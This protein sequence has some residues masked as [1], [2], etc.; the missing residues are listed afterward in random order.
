MM[1]LTID[2][3]CLKWNFNFYLNINAQQTSEM[4]QKQM[5]QKLQ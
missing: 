4:H 5:R 3:E 1:N 2:G